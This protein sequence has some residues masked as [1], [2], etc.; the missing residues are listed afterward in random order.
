MVATQLSAAAHSPAAPGLHRRF[1]SG[2]IAAA[3]HSE[4]SAICGVAMAQHD[5]PALQSSGPSQVSGRG[6]GRPLQPLKVSQVTTIGA[7]CFTAF[8]TQQTLPVGH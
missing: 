1:Q 4:V 3:L 2:E 8:C 5:S 6:S 7:S